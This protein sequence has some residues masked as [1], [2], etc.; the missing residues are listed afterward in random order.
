[1]PNKKAIEPVKKV[2]ADIPDRGEKLLYL[3]TGYHFPGQTIENLHHDILDN[4]TNGIPT[5]E[6]DEK[7]K[8]ASLIYLLPTVLKLKNLPDFPALDL[9]IEN[10]GKFR[11]HDIHTAMYDTY[12][13]FLQSVL[14]HKIFGRDSKFFEELAIHLE[15]VNFDE[16]SN[17][18]DPYDEKGYTLANTYYQCM[19]ELGHEPSLNEVMLKVTEQGLDDLVS[20]SRETCRE[21][22]KDIGLS[23]RDSRGE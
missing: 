11:I 7:V 18:W 17:G 14:I 23:L 19:D 16:D 3:M 15:H 8:G 6:I 22:I 10:V 12:I 2:A 1:M 21:Y 13:E 4:L 20:K 5:S 9:G